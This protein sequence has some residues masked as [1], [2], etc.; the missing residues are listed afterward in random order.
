[1][2]MISIVLDT[3]FMVHAVSFGVDFFSEFERIIDSRYNLCI[4]PGT[5]GELE[6]LINEGKFS[7]KKASKIV[8]GLIKSKRISI[9]KTH[10]EM[11]VD[12]MLASL[13]P[14]LYAVATQDKVLK[15]RLKAGKI[16]VFT[17]RQKKYIIEEK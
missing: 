2:V 14:K 5:L 1:M 16:R 8:L 10:A 15:G 7:E 12:D 6:K 3:N 13:D 4:V 11:P 9:I 17:L